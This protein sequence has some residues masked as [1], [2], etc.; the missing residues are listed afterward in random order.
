MHDHNLDDLIIDESI[1]PKQSGIKNFLTLIGL[2]IVLLVLGMVLVKLYKTQSTPSPLV[3]KEDT[4]D[5]IAPELKKLQ[6]PSKPTDE[7]KEESLLSI[8]DVDM[9]ESIDAPME[10]SKDSYESPNS[11][12]QTEEKEPTETSDIAN[13]RVEITQEFT[14]V[15]PEVTQ[16]K[17]PKEPIVTPKPYTPPPKAPTV[18]SKR[19]YVQV[20]SF[21]STPSSRFLSVIRNN[22][23]RYTITKANAKGL[24]KLLIGPYATRAEVNRVLFRVRDRINKQSFVVKR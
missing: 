4:V 13:Q 20:G 3:I 17:E 16:P 23:F 11:L 24:K 10:T 12:P 7:G 2:V 6:T 14:Q 22:G 21:S 9:Q 18:T 1:E 15:P 8:T 19:Y 5:Y